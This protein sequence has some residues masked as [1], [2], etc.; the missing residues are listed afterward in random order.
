ML[1]VQVE[2]L[3]T[4]TGTPSTTRSMRK[5]RQPASPPAMFCTSTMSSFVPATKGVAAWAGLVARARLAMSAGSE[6]RVAPILLSGRVIGRPVE[7][8]LGVL[9]FLIDRSDPA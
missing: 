3:A 2:S 4:A 8:G 6:A 7:E 1:F 5:P 9:L